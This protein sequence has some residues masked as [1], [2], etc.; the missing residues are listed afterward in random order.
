VVSLD[1]SELFTINNS[2]I[3]VTLKYFIAAVV[4]TVAYH[5]LITVQIINIFVVAYS[6]TTFFKQKQIS[7]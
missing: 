4:L 5:V 2:L 3:F 7:M 1:Y 6:Y